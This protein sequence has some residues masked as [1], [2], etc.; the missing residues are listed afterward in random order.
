M[1]RIFVVAV[2]CLALAACTTTNTKVA[3]LGGAKPPATAQV[4]TLDPDVSLGLL[5]AAGLVEPRDDW[6]KS[7]QKNLSTEVARALQAKSH[8]LKALNQQDA[9]AGRTG[10]LFRLNEAVGTSIRAYG[11]ILPT[12]KGSFDW[13][14]GEG[15]QVLGQTYGS[16]YALFVSA[17]G[18]YASGGRTLAFIG[19]AALGVGIPMGQQQAYASLVDLKTGRVIWFNTILAGSGIDMRE[20][21]GAKSIVGSLLKDLPL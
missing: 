17:R 11:P 6:S 18:S 9:M 16:D 5:T 3:D 10:Q 8:T 19:M 20:P 15:A 12:K 7:A 13:T 14:L 21:D 1:N 2:A 4:L